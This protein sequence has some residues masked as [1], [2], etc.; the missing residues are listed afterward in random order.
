MICS[1]LRHIDITAVYRDIFSSDAW[2]PDDGT[3]ANIHPKIYWQASM[4]LEMRADS[5][6]ENFYSEKS[7]WIN[8]HPEC[9]AAEVS[10]YI[11]A[12]IDS[13]A[14]Q[15]NMIAPLCTELS[16]AEWLKQF[17]NFAELAACGDKVDYFEME[18]LMLCL[19][20]CACWLY[21]RRDM[22][23][24]MAVLSRVE[25]VS[26]RLAHIEGEDFKSCIQA[27]RAASKR[28]EETNKQRALALARWDEDGAK[29]SS[30]TAFSELNHK[31]Y[32]V[33]PVTL[34]RWIT[35]HQKTQSKHSSLPVE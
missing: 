11:E 13:L 23:G 21:E 6:M 17:Q 18:A 14:S 10:D 30:K 22:D 2:P 29:Y 1:Y 35:K 28:H 34:L 20:D 8:L 4:L 3:L 19:Y 31:Q 12:D 32:D 7:R 5:T 15:Y 27:R 24:L 33:K 25:Q 9:I 16:D 26:G